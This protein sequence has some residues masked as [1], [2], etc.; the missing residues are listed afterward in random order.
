VVEKRY[1]LPPGT[2]VIV[3]EPNPRIV[4][5]TF[6]AHDEWELDLAAP[7]G[8][9]ALGTYSGAV[10]YPFQEGNEPGL[11]LSGAGRG[12]NEINGEF[13]INKLQRGGDGHVKE[14]AVN[15]NQRCDNGRQPLRGMVTVGGQ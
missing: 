8:E 12:C 5:L 13:I 9:L 4:E 11:S 7:E 3:K 2:P 15:F 10:R 1:P 6:A 14:L